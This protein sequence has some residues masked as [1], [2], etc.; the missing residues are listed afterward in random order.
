MRET[1][2]S[3]TPTEAVGRVRRVWRDAPLRRKL[4]VA[5]GL[6]LVCLV[7]T[8]VAVGITQRQQADVRVQARAENRAL[9]A[10][11]AVELALLDA[12]TGM[13]GYLA[14]GERSFLGPYED[15]G[16]DL[17]AARADL[18]EALGEDAAIADEVDRRTSAAAVA[19]I[20]L[21]DAAP[22][23]GPLRTAALAQARERMDDAR[24][25]LDALH[26]TV[27]AQ[28]GRAPRPD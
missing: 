26:A 24:Q 12:E 3:P 14:T 21:V 9:T 2:A 5:V 16:R 17:A 7:P 18:D 19:V 13:R 10:L 20:S 22:P 8:G 6:P 28:P 11:S 1:A 25:A 15:A 27:S 23:A 4:L